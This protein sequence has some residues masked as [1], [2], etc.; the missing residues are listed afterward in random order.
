[1]IPT[2]LPPQRGE[3]FTCPCADFLNTVHPHNVGKK[4]ITSETVFCLTG[5]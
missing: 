2:C 5:G 4:F 3:Y 1:M